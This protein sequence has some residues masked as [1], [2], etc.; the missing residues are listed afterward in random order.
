MP[1]SP[2]PPKIFDVP[3]F[4][5]VTSRTKA[6]RHTALNHCCD[7][8]RG[9]CISRLFPGYMYYT[10][11]LLQASSGRAVFTGCFKQVHSSFPSGLPDLW[12]FWELQL[13]MQARFN[14]LHRVLRRTGSRPFTHMA[15]AN[16]TNI[17]RQHNAITTAP[18][19]VTEY[20]ASTL[21][22]VSHKTRQ[23][24]KITSFQPAWLI[25]CSTPH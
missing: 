9:R 6:W 19:R 13:S 21:Q 4:E 11:A 25:R 24:K 10:S 14:N 15:Q 18:A 2:S 23:D 3:G 16:T 12:N 17:I 1:G 20:D 22:P 8:K 5:P 7:S